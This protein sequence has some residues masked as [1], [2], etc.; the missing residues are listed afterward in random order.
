MP[1]N[2]SLILMSYIRLNTI[3]T[4][5]DYIQINPITYSGVFYD[6]DFTT[7]YNR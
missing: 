2:Q 3:N 4:T 5:D 7:T 1:F 6:I